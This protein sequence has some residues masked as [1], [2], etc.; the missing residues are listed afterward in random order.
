M[1]IEEAKKLVSEGLAKVQEGFNQL[2]EIVDGIEGSDDDSPPSQF[3]PVGD[4][5]RQL[6]ESAKRK[7]EKA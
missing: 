2:C 4:L 1:S 5:A 3:K 6:K 7:P